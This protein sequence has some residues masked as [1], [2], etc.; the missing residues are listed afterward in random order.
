MESP[1]RYRSI[2]IS[3]VHLG[4]RESKA[5]F[6]LD[7]LDRH[8]ADRYYLVGD[9]VDGWALKRSWYWPASHNA[10]IQEL[11]ERAKHAEVT[12][13]PGNHDEAARSFPGLRFGG[14][15]VQMQATHTT[16]DGRRFLVLHGDEFDGVIRHARWLS[17]L[18]AWAYSGCLKLNRYVNRVRRWA[19][20]PYWSLSSYLKQ[21]TKQAVQFIADFENAVARR[22]ADRGADGVI[23]GHIH[24]PEMRSIR[25]VQY[26]NTG[27]WVESCTALVEHFDGRLELLRWVP[28][29]RGSRRALAAEAG[30]SGDGHS[31]DVRDVSLPDPAP[32]TTS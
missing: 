8:E 24:H 5:S 30:P 16:A 12:Y 18:G 20:L 2:W 28:D 27:D 4:L 29:G 3:D 15:S 31:A 11:L 32:E 21:Q 26:A 23:C 7:F 22:A 13:V 17:V 14:V 9:I 19:G 25:D 6:L 1:N 10:V